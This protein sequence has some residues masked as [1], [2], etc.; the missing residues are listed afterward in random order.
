ML[1]SQRLGKANIVDFGDSLADLIKMSIEFIVTLISV[2]NER[3]CVLAIEI[4]D[5]ECAL[6]SIFR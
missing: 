6:L 3:D 2:V 5:I 1:C 4:K